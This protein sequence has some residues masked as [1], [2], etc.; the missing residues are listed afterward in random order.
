[1]SRCR[2]PGRCSSGGAAPDNAVVGW[3]GGSPTTDPAIAHHAFQ[4]ASPSRDFR[5][6]I[7]GFPK[8]F[9]NSLAEPCRIVK[10]NTTE[11]SEF[12]LC[13][14]LQFDDLR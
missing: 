11:G 2:L 3:A 14:R 1:M 5:E 10:T 7:F 13:E 9:C 6:K 12:L 8:N 4:S